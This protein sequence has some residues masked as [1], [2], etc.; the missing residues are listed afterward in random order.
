MADRRHASSQTDVVL[1]ARP[2][3]LATALVPGFTK[4]T[5]TAKSMRWWRKER[6]ERGRRRRSTRRDLCHLDRRLQAPIVEFSNPQTRFSPLPPPPLSDARLLQYVFSF[7]Y[8]CDVLTV[9][10]RHRRA[11]ARRLATRSS[12]ATLPS[13]VSPP[14][15]V[16]AEASRLKSTYH[17]LTLRDYGS[18][19]I[20]QVLPTVNPRPFVAECGKLRVLNSYWV[21]KDG[22]DATRIRAYSR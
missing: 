11:E 6:E 16:F 10:M 15:G 7:I 5:T 9:Q 17:T 19:L 18:M 20:T 14:S 2:G 4:Q 8:L 12:R 3:R 13:T 1:R 21:D 22:D